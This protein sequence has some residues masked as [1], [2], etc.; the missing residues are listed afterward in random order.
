MFWPYPSVPSAGLCPYWHPSAQPWADASSV[1]PQQNGSS[2]GTGVGDALAR[3]AFCAARLPASAGGS[4]PLH[5]GGLVDVVV[6]VDVDVDV[7]DDVLAIVD[8]DVLVLVVVVGV[9]GGRSPTRFPTQPST[10]ISTVEASP[11]CA[12]PVFSSAFVK[13]M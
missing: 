11:I 7:V 13:A 12:Q 10:A 3:T 1:E 2:A 4:L 5:T 9:G 6:E 8:D